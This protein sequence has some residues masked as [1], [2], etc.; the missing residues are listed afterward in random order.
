M[1]IVY[2]LW[3]QH[4]HFIRTIIL[5]IQREALEKWEHAVPK[6]VARRKNKTWIKH[7]RKYIDYDGELPKR[8]H[9]KIYKRWIKMGNGD[10][11]F[12]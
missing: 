9:I 3:L 10:E 12:M 5:W 2:I 7:I 6:G 1:I 11:W 4:F 8:E